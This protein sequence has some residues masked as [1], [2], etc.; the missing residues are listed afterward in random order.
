[1]SAPA[2][3]LNAYNGIGAKKASMPIYRMIILGILAG[4]LIGMG[5]VVSTTGSLAVANPGL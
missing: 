3:F 2:E 4:V 1:M 5:A